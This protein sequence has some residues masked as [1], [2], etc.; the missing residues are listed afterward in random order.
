VATF[1][2]LWQALAYG[3]AGL[4]ADDGVLRIDPKL[5]SPWPAL[6][7][8]RR[9]R[10]RRVTVT[11]RHDEVSV[12]SSAPVSV[13]AADGPAITGPH[14]SWALDTRSAPWSAAAGR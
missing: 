6:A 10:G 5:P 9:F 12:T 14:A 2:G 13:A 8:R 11:V 4:R 1:G 7:L 3:F